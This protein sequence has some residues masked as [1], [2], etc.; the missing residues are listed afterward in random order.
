MVNCITERRFGIIEIQDE[1]LKNMSNEDL[2]MIFDLLGII[3]RTDCS[4]YN[5]STKYIFSRPDLAQVPIGKSIPRYRI[6][7]D[8]LNKCAKLTPSDVYLE[9]GI[10]PIFR[11]K[12]T[13]ARY[14]VLKTGTNATN[15]QDGQKMVE[16]YAEHD[17]EFENPFYREINEFMEKFEEINDTADS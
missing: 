13:K 6:V 10:C 3:V 11:N 15:K 17:I 9:H 8:K 4:I 1:H 2:K 7:V 5:L 12:K 14:M 16:Y